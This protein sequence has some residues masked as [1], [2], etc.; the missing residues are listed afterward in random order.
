M[1]ADEAQPPGAV[2]AEIA[3]GPGA[4]VVIEAAGTPES[5]LLGTRLARRGGALAVVAA[6]RTATPLHLES[7]WDRNLTIHTGQV[8]TCSVPWLLDLLASGRLD[9]A[10]LVT[11]TRP[12][13]RLPDLYDAFARGPEAG[14]LKL[15]A[16][17][18]AKHRRPRSAHALDGTP[19]L[20]GPVGP[21][22]R[23]GVPERPMPNHAA[24]REP[25]SGSGR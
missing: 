23:A 7:L 12:M 15:V 2:I 19:A 22:G 25:G 20:P 13:T 10:G 18:R 4:D 14:A 21:A 1:G 17:R 6:H 24:R 11:G 9:V 8:D 3:E 16:V 5:F